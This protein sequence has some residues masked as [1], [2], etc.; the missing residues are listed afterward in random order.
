RRAAPARAQ[1]GFRLES[2]SAGRTDDRLPVEIVEP[3]AAAQADALLTQCSFRQKTPP[4][5]CLVP[6]WRALCHVRRSL[7]K[8]KWQA[9]RGPCERAAVAPAPSCARRTRR[10]L[11]AGRAPPERG[12]RATG[13][14]E[15]NAV[16]PLISRP[17]G[18]FAGDA[19]APG[20]KSI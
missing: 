7:S 4:R 8:A 19:A 11:T 6:A 20:D 17:V 16:Q 5:P 3:G 9:K 18:R 10:P 1:E 12:P 13:I 2:R 14:E 15:E